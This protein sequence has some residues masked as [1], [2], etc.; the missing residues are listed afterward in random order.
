MTGILLHMILECCGVSSTTMTCS[1]WL[2]QMEM[3]NLSFCS[4]R[5]RRRSLSRKGGH[6]QGGYTSTVTAASCLHQMCTHGYL[7]LLLYWRHHPLF[8][9][10]RFGQ[11]C[12]SY[13]FVCSDYRRIS[14]CL[15]NCRNWWSLHCTLVCW[16]MLSFLQGWFWYAILLW[17][18]CELV[19]LQ[20]GCRFT[21][22]I[23]Y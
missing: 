18:G 17:L 11:R 1:W 22:C 15:G 5:T 13:G 7:T 20:A 2:G 16:H 4:G 6:F 14:W 9:P 8:G 10:S 23:F 19:V 3:C 21:F 12:C